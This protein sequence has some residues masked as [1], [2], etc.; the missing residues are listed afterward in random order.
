M[1]PFTTDIE[2]MGKEELKELL[3]KLTLYRDLRK[4][5][6]KRGEN[7]FETLQTGAKKLTVEYFSSAD[8]SYVENQA[9][10]MYKNIF[11]LEVKKEDIEF[12][13]ND[14]ILGGMRVFMDDKVLDLSYL[15]IENQFSK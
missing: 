6:G 13:T 15:K 11:G 12:K 2:K 10:A 7:I 14:D 3:S 8:K 5:L 1:N 9:L 4:W